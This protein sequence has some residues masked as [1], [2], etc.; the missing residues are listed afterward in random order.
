[1]TTAPAV[2]PKTLAAIQEMCPDDHGEFLRKLLH[3]YTRDAARHVRKMKE[4]LERGDAESLSYAA[5]G[6]RGGSGI[7]GAATLLQLT[8]QIET[9]ANKGDLG[10]IGGLV[11]ACSVEFL[12][13]KEELDQVLAQAS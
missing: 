12:R 1:M 13:V 6:L 2:D 5:H 9:T 11:D 7:V 4:S 8:S 10:H 3:T